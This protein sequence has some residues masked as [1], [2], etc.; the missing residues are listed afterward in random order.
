[1]DMKV[2]VTQDDI[3]EAITAYIE[4]KGISTPVRKIDF[5][6]VRKP[7]FAI[8]AEV[9]VS[10]NELAEDDNKSA[11]KAPVKRQQKA[12]EK[13]KTVEEAAE[14]EA[15]ET[16]GQVKYEAPEAAVAA[17]AE[18]PKTEEPAPEAVSD[19]EPAPAKKSLF[20]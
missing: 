8:T 16:P 4:N 20:G 11:K 9:V 3:K 12:K 7:E 2:T 15:E 10:E 19:E 18:T 1:M 13:P 5:V 14:I 6:T 17:P